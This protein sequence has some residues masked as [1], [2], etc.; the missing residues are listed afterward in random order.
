MFSRQ[1]T[2]VV[3]ISTPSYIMRCFVSNIAATKPAVVTSRVAKEV[4]EIFQQLFSC[5]S[6]TSNSD[7]C[8]QCFILPEVKIWRC[9]TGSSYS[10]CFGT[11]QR[12]NSNDSHCFL[13]R[14]VR[15][16]RNQSS[17]TYRYTGNGCCKARNAEM[18]LHEISSRSLLNG[19]L[20]CGTCRAVIPVTILYNND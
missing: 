18:V 8:L 12:K 3:L 19:I 7:V 6:V 15:S 17:S 10:S 16:R 13:G 2:S 5:F 14:P 1:S 11:M 4:C 20:D 9:E